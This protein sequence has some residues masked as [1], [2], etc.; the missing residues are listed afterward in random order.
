MRVS[1]QQACGRRLISLTPL[2]DVVFILLVF[3]MLASSFLDWRSIQLKLP[4]QATAGAVG[5]VALV[6]SISDNGVLKL[7]G[8]LIESVDLG[9]RLR[10]LLSNDVDLPILIRAAE[11]VPLQRSIGVL[12]EI[13]AAG[14]RNVSLSRDRRAAP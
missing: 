6:V 13:T 4:A 7:N 12:E 14:G 11:G 2:V 3:F 10:E 8:E 5:D 9:T 1:R